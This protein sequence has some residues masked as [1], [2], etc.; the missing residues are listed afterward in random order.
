MTANCISLNRGAHLKTAALHWNEIYRAI[1]QLQYRTTVLI[2]FLFFIFLQSSVCPLNSSALS[3]TPGARTLPMYVRYYVA[4][5]LPKAGRKHNFDKLVL[6]IFAEDAV[7]PA[8][9]SNCE[10][11]SCQSYFFALPKGCERRPFFAADGLEGRPH[12]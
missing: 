8:F 5:T 6:S 10:V 3:P 12:G 7:N 9:R 1:S 11:R 2:Y 4:R